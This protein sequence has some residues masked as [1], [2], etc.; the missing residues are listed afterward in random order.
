MH[1]PPRFGPA[2]RAVCARRPAA[3][4]TRMRRRRRARP[5]PGRAR[6]SERDGR[7]GP[8]PPPWIPSQSGAR[9][10]PAACEKEG[11]RAR[12]PLNAPRW[13]LSAAVWKVKT[14]LRARP[15]FPLTPTPG[16][17]PG[18]ARG[19]LAGPVR[20]L[21]VPRKYGSGAVRSQGGRTRQG[22]VAGPPRVPSES[23]R[24]IR[25]P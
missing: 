11:P 13:G 24:R 8:G 19:L 2:R 20:P 9:S 14:P 1:A 3:G 17:A 25:V 22:R 15:G 6:G 4:A 18:P 12:R 7:P 16:C 23:A 21:P 10:A 5:G